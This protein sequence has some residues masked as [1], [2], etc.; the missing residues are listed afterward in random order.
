MLSQSALRAFLMHRTIYVFDPDTRAPVAE[1]WYEAG[2]EVRMRHADGRPDQGRWGLEGDAYW[3]QYDGFRGG[4]VNSFT[5]EP[6]DADTAQAYHTDGRRAYLQSHI[7]S[8]S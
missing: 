8:L 1:V 6:L 5:L 4:S 7:Q 3:T 2:G